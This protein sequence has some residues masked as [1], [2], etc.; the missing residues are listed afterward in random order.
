MLDAGCWIF[1]NALMV[2][3]KNFEY[4]ATSI[5]DHPGLAGVFVATQWLGIAFYATIKGI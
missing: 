5:Q 2:K 3:S 1:K 4:Q